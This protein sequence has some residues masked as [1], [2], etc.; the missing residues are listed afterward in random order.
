[1]LALRKRAVGQLSV[2]SWPASKRILLG[3]ECGIVEWLRSGYSA[4]GSKIKPLSMS[5]SRILGLENTLLLSQ[6]VRRPYRHQLSGEYIVPLDI[7]LSLRRA[8][9]DAL[10]PPL[11]SQMQSKFNDKVERI[12]FAQSL[13][14]S[15][16]LYAAY[17]DLAKREDD[18]TVA[19]AERLGA[20]TTLSICRMRE[21]LDYQNGGRPYYGDIGRHVDSVFQKELVD[22]RQA[23]AA[24]VYAER[25]VPELKKKKK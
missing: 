19:E 18:I 22:V 9:D 13:G 16:W 10:E 4:L 3:R 25:G 1:M 21:K 7:D 24:Y 11:A 5:D 20:E 14:D 23:G 8:I 12:L 6:Q 17:G 15:E 2:S